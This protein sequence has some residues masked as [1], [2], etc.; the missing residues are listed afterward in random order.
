MA[1]KQN[2]RPPPRRR[3]QFSE[4][5][6]IT[7]RVAEVNSGNDVDFEP[8]AA[9]PEI[10]EEEVRAGRAPETCIDVDWSLSLPRGSPVCRA[11]Q[12]RRLS[13]PRSSCVAH[14]RP[15]RSSVVRV[16]CGRSWQRELP[17]DRLW[18][19]LG[20]RSIGGLSRLSSGE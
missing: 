7:E 5:A 9:V 1:T 11:R 17:G 19:R 6:A 3:S 4:M 13:D 15:Y 12:N 20:A 8:A 18:L 16:A 2:R 14:G 10:S